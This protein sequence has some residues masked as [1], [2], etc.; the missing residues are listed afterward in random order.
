MRLF[1][2][3]FFNLLFRKAM[4]S[5]EKNATLGCLEYQHSLD[6]ILDSLLAD[7]HDFYQRR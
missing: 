5:G 4:E 7:L 3:L 6:L 1:I 2:Y